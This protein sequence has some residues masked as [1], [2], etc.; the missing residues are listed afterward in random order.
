MNPLLQ[1]LKE[2]L[3]WQ[4][5]CFEAAATATAERRALLPKM[6]L[7]CVRREAKAILGLLNRP[8]RKPRPA[9]TGTGLDK[10]SK[11]V[12]ATASNVNGIGRAITATS[13]VEGRAE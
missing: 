3:V 5:T 8:K 4:R 9:T 12:S 7:Q 6:L 10:Q 2:W 11:T 1:K 13:G